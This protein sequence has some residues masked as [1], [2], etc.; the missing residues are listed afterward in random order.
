MTPSS[1]SMWKYFIILS[2][3]LPSNALL[4]NQT[5]QQLPLNDF[6]RITTKSDDAFQIILLEKLYSQYHDIVNQPA[7]DW[8]LKVKSQ[9]GLSLKDFDGG[10]SG[11][12]SL[13]KLFPDS[14]TKASVG[15]QKRSPFAGQSNQDALNLV[16]SQDII[17]NAFGKNTLKRREI[18]GIEAD[19]VN[20]QTIEAYEDYFASLIVVY[21]DWYLAAQNL[22]F[23]QGFFSESEK[24]LA[25]IQARKKKNIALQV[26][27][28]KLILQNLDRLE[29]KVTAE[30][31]L[32]RAY[33]KIKSLLGPTG[34][35]VYMPAKITKFAEMDTDF[36]ANIDERIKRSRTTEL[37]LLITQK[38]K[39]L[40][41][42]STDELLP[43]VQ[44][45]F[46]VNH[47]GKSGL[48]SGDSEPSTQV[49][50]SLS[51]PFGNSHANARQEIA[52][53]NIKKASLSASSRKKI[54]A[55]EIGDLG[56][57]IQTTRSVLTVMQKK[58][59]IAESI[60]QQEETSYKYGKIILSEVISARVQLENHRLTALNTEVTLQKLIV[61]WL[62]L[63]DQLV[64]KLP[65]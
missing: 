65:L 64:T 38:Q 61:E 18:I 47:A 26:E 25:N 59:A 27:V 58:V 28:D 30:I 40:F 20:Y 21:L 3:L 16:I 34:N 50:V 33:D 14:G 4:S 7:T 11:L 44:V 31:T 37:L 57:R 8:L 13:E 19:L 45:L 49:G 12:I 6:I 32:S 23:A 42:L 35:R 52:R 51:Y 5:E 46:E 22:K 17:Q 41:E 54:M 62:R 63:T 48:W 1:L 9:L 2:G 53:L 36:T 15:Y 56:R 43:A 39:G 29:K 10:I 60:Q 55:Q 24:Q